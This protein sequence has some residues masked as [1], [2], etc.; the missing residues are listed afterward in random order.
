M[1][2]P[3]KKRL[4]GTAL[5]SIL[6]VFISACG[7][8]SGTS[9]SN[10]GG[11]SQKPDPVAVDLPI[12]YIKRPLPVDENKQPVFPDLMDPTAFNPGAAIYVK[13]RAT[14]SAAPVNITDSAFEKGALYDVKDL[15]TSPD[16]KKLL[17]SMHAPLLKNV[18]KDK[19]PKWQIWEYDLT[20]KVLRPIITSPLV[21]S[22]GH[23]VSPRY[24]PDGRILFSSNRQIRSKA[25]LL[26]D[27][28]PQFSALE[29]SGDTPAFVLHSMKADGTDIQQL[30][31]NQSHDIQPAVLQ[32][33]KILYT[34]WDQFGTDKL[35]FYTANAD[36]SQVERHYGYFSL[37]IPPETANA[38]RNRLF[39]PQEMPDGRIA[40]IL[41]PNEAMLGGDMV[42]IDTKHFFENDLQVPAGGGTGSAQS[43]ISIL[44]INIKVGANEFSQHG[45]YSSLTPLFDGTNRLLVSWSECRL[46]E[47]Q[48]KRLVPCTDTWLATAG[49][50]EADPLYGIW[51]YNITLQT[52][53]PVV[54]AEEG[55]MF[56][57]PV[58]LEPRPAPTY[59]P[60][61]FEVDLAAESVGMLHIRSVYDMDGKFNNFGA[62]AFT[63]IEQI[64]Q[65]APDQR[66]ARFVRLIKAVSIPDK[67]TRDNLGDN[68]Y[69]DLFKQFNN[70]R[71][72]L[73]YA[74]VEPDG[75][76]KV[77]VPADVAFT[78]EI[79]NK[80]GKRIGALHRNW[81]QVRPGEVRECNGCHNA[82]TVNAGHGR[83]DAELPSI[84]KGATGTRFAN[85][86]RFDPLGTPVQPKAG[87]TMAEFASHTTYCLIPGDGTTCA[88]FTNKAK[89]NFR[90]PSVDLVFDDEWTDTA[91][92]AKTTSF[93]YRY[94][95]L[96]LVASDIHSP[97]AEACM[98]NDG[99][100]SLCRVTINYENHI[101][102]IW[103]R[104]RGA[105]NGI[106]DTTCIT[107]HT[108]TDAAGNVNMK[109]PDGQLELLGTK[110]ANNQRMLSYTELTTTTNKQILGVNGIP[111][112]QIPVCELAPADLYPDIPACVIVRDTNGVPTCN[113]VTNCPFV[114]DAITGAVVL[115]AMGNPTPLNQTIGVPASM[116]RGSALGSARFFNK[117]ANF[118]AATDT[119]DHRGL[120]NPSELKL[121]SEWLDI[122][123]VYYNNPFDTIR[124]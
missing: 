50:K 45:R 95:N 8:G 46:I 74:P 2:Q 24:L 7:G 96:A 87:E 40:A 116:S 31:Y 85:A 84:N 14:A 62:T 58:S 102:P 92:R 44:P 59:T 94:K 80:D 33:G 71:E 27:G 10:N 70:L 37:N 79:L 97:T 20:S 103:E 108:S 76:V 13:D 4:T 9:T 124:P 82:V 57:E 67:T 110:G 26:D 119:V 73:G 53:Q 93:A 77:K 28:K 90:A 18:T 60:P 17:F 123:G 49:V 35:S 41:K 86:L 29:E 68:T 38:P 121:L 6:C 54:L 11:G 3:Q 101:Q 118:D 99:W 114:Q 1:L 63:S 22:V 25:I 23:D 32:S 51:V 120:L 89:S 15:S 112:T 5:A 122:G 105:A 98:E 81:L 91:V 56:S 69:G 111:T 72:I 109:V 100:S 78:L 30:T 106:A 43:S 64:A 39:R 61:K 21:A 113:G 117:F 66:P 48:D 16:G 42:V 65:A 12:A 83:S 19:Q 36:G 47:P 107:C 34:H 52:Q 115:D 88:L 104:A 55:M 75:S